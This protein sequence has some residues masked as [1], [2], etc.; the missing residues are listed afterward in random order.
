MALDLG[1]KTA[2]VTGSS[3]G[4]GYFIAEA[5]ARAGANVVITARKAAEVEEA[6]RALNELGGGRVVGVPS[7]VR[8]YEDVRRIISTAVNEL[9]GLDILVNNAGVGRFAPIDEIT[10]EQWHQMIDTNLTGAFYCARE[11]VPHLRARGGGWII[12]IGSLA[13]KN[14]IQGGTAY[15]ASKFGLLGFSEAMMLDVR[16]DGIRV[17]CIMPGSVDT[18]F[19][20]KK[21][22][23]ENAWMIQPRDLA[24]IVMDLLAMPANVLPSRIEVRP[25]KRQAPG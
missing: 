25:A 8:E 19:N 9:G 13:G 23:P 11:A 4:I 14:P 18:W 16:E 1:G 7:D 17:T 10:V 21:P 2:V 15:N 20:G 3:K 6:A 22:S 12:N 5:L 24:R